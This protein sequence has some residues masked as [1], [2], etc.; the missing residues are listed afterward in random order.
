[1]QIHRKDNQ[2]FI[3]VEAY[4]GEHLVMRML[5]GAFIVSVLSYGY[6][7]GVTIMNMIAHQESIAKAEQLKST[8]SS[9]EHEYLKLTKS[10]TPELGASLGLSETTNRSYVRRPGAVGTTQGKPGDL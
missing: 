3:Q 6:F 10:I 2:V 9:L 7:V 5:T 4:R 8:V 1:M